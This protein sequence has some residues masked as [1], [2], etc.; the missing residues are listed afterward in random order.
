MAALH[1]TSAGAEPAKIDLTARLAEIEASAKGRLGVAVLD[2]KTGTLYGQRD[3]ERFPMCSTFKVL[4]AGLVLDRVDRGE[5]QLDRR[6]TFTK[7]DIAP[8]SPVTEKHAGGKGM[9]LAELCAAAIEISDNT[10]ANLMLKSFGG[11]EALTAWLRTLGDKA[12]R[13]D[14]T[15]PALNDTK[16]GDPRDGTTPRSMVYT[17][18]RIL[19]GN[20]VSKASEKMLIDWMADAK[21][22]TRRIR[23]GLPADWRAGDKTGTCEGSTS[24]VAIIWPPDHPPVIV[25][26]YLA[27]SK[28]PA[29]KREAVLADVGRAVAAAF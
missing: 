7:K 25:A 15:E 24:D 26:A 10:A 28:L 17:L 9:T 1:V 23:A 4:A 3:L 16:P 8:Y 6:I 5:E 11:P 19:L 29:A 2:T 13:L 14:R 20:V 21:T 27:E 12:T 22:G 18:Q